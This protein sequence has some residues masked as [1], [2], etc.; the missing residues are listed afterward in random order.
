MFILFSLH[1]QMK[2]YFKYDFNEIYFNKNNILFKNYSK[3][4]NINYFST[5]FL[6]FNKIK[7]NRLLDYDIKFNKIQKTNY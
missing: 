2:Y 6:K 5:I 1:Y 3:L 4:C 7:Q